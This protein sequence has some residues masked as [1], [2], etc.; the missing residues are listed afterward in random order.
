MKNMRNKDKPLLRAK[1]ELPQ[2]NETIQAL[3]DHARADDYL[4]STVDENKY[5]IIEE[6]MKSKNKN[7]LDVI[8]LT[9]NRKHETKQTKQIEKMKPACKHFPP[10]TPSF[11][12]YTGNCLLFLSNNNKMKMMMIKKLSI[13]KWRSKETYTHR[14]TNFRF[15]LSALSEKKNAH[16]DIR[17]YNFWMIFIFPL[18]FWYGWCLTYHSHHTIT[19]EK[20]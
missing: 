2:N 8:D 11:N 6:K 14:T 16:F 15:N 5:W 9:L 10:T 17:I 18:F 4:Q 13:K 7:P 19:N 12:R 20:Q 3:I 1:S